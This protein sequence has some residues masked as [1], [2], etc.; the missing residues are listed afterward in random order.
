MQVATAAADVSAEV[1]VVELRS[2]FGA[3]TLDGSKTAGVVVTDELA[4]TP[5][6]VVVA[7]AWG[8]M[9]ENTEVTNC[10]IRRAS[11]GVESP[12]I[13][14]VAAPES[15]AGGTT[16]TDG[17]GGG[18]VLVGIG[19]NTCVGVSEVEDALDVSLDGVE[20]VTAGWSDAGV[21]VACVVVLEVVSVDVALGET[22][23]LVPPPP[24]PLVLPCSGT[25]PT[26]DDEAMNRYAELL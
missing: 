22:G 14:V 8:M 21:V 24:P 25:I 19:K 5:S 4:P 6:S 7:N 23:T 1:I 13:L 3:E 12:R 17:V 18:G 16:G 26:G 11:G 9:S 10:S 2:G 15:V 20:D